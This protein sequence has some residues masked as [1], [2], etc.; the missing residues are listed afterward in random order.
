MAVQYHDYY[1]ILGVNRDASQEEIQK[2]YR[3]LA[4]KFH[5]DVN[6]S[7]GAI[8]KFKEI[9]EANEV[10]KDPEKR[11]RYDAL[12]ANW[13]EGQEFTPPPGWEGVFGNFGQGPQSGGGRT[14]QFG[15]GG[16][17]SDFFSVL[18]GDAGPFAGGAFGTGHHYDQT[19]SHFSPREPQAQEANLTISLEDAVRGGTKVVSLEMTELDPSGTPRRT[20]RTLQ[21]KI[22]KGVTDNSVIRLKGQGGQGPG[23]KAVDLHLRLHLAPHPQ[24]R[25]SGHDIYTQL[26]I[27]P[28]EAALGAKVPVQTLHGK[29]TV[30]IPSGS[31]SGGQLRLRTKGL[32]GKSGIGGD[33]FVE[34]KITVPKSLSAKEK[35]LFENLS[36]V[37][38]FN[39]RADK[40]SSTTGET[41]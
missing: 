25:V 3:K 7:K 34:L 5:P 33:M 9:N 27:T 6:K 4:R 16:G 12:G 22:P 15:S 10:L 19:A 24:Y 26:P 29:V 37:S 2:A 36:E 23:G 28:W 13:K 14:F 31:Q 39:P 32:P 8:E 35:E 11:K 20:T 21:V 40:I 18:F 41:K 17:F 1:T 30:N 38:S